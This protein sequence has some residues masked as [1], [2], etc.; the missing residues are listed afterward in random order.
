MKGEVLNDQRAWLGFIAARCKASSSVDSSALASCLLRYY[1]KWIKALQHM[2]YHNGGVTFVQRS[3][4]LYP[5]EEAVPPGPQ[6]RIGMD[7]SQ[8]GY[9]NA[10]WPQANPEAPEWKAWNKAM[11]AATLALASANRQPPATAWKALVDADMDM[12]V[13]ASLGIVEKDLVTTTVDSQWYGHGAAHAN[14]NFI[15]FNWML[16]EKRE[17][18]PEDVFR[19]GSGW[20]AA[21][22]GQCERSVSRQLIQELGAD[23]A[24][25]WLDN[26]PKELHG[27]ILDPRNWLLDGK[28][29]TIPFEPYAVAC[30]ACTPPPVT[31]PWTDLKPY[32]QPGFVLPK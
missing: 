24:K 22:L 20:D 3:I 14:L 18:R 5:P 6:V 17:M 15:Q 26:L 13:N 21:I 19:A 25:I 9:L 7:D 29:L 12:D 10:S 28:G 32:L 31:I 30:H 2:V 27:L 1:D 4:T 16:R 23:N 8:P 11:E